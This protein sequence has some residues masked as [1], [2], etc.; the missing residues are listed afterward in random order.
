MYTCAL[1]PV[2]MHVTESAVWV[3][4]GHCA[5]RWSATVAR[6]AYDWS[7][8]GLR[9]VYGSPTT[10][11]RLVYDW[12][13]TGLRLVYGWSTAGLRLV[14]DRLQI[15]WRPSVQSIREPITHRVPIGLGNDRA[16]PTTGVRRACPHCP[17]FTCARASKASAGTRKRNCCPCRGSQT[18]PGDCPA[19]TARSGRASCRERVSSPV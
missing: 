11:R 15:M 3:T 6:M 5:P 13:T 14:Y 10:G 8:T 9:L 12:S 19:R 1:V 18:W 16:T 17:V 4:Q 2:C 7:T